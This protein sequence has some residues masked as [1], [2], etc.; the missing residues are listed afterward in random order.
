MVHTVIERKEIINKNP[1]YNDT[2]RARIPAERAVRVL[3]KAVEGKLDSSNPVHEMRYKA[4]IQAIK[5]VL[6]AQQAIAIAITQTPSIE[7]HDIEARM[8]LAGMDPAEA[9][10]LIG[11]KIIDKPLNAK[12][13]A[14]A[15]DGE[16]VA[17]HTQEKSDPDSI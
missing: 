15:I 16:L 2:L 17:D 11:A 14:E 6:P 5:L 12:D 10:K 4:A 1:S 9:W 8:I 3:T 7:R 13:K